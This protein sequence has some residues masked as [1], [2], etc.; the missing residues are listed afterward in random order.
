MH[1]LS[2]AA[3]SSIIQDLQKLGFTDYELQVYVAL[4][5]TSPVTA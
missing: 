4:H 1:P 2:R 5:A 3:S